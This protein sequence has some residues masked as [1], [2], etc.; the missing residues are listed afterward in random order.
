M[1]LISSGCPHAPPPPSLT[2][3]SFGVSFSWHRVVVSHSLEKRGRP[4][5]ACIWICRAM[6]DGWQTVSLRRGLRVW[7]LWRL[8]EVM[9][10]GAAEIQGVKAMTLCLLRRS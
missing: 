2:V 5:H 3:V 10:R 8:T 9:V 4:L 6:V 1:E 7:A